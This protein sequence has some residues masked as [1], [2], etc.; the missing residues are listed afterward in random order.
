[1]FEDLAL[2]KTGAGPLS[3]KITPGKTK[4]AEKA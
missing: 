2:K 4:V 1:L 3:S